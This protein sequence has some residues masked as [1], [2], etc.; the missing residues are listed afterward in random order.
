MFKETEMIGDPGSAPQ[1][2][3]RPPDRE[4]CQET[5]C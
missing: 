1:Q 3:Q 5:E 4:D 2:T